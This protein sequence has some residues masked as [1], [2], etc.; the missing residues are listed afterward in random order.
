MKRKGVRRETL[1]GGVGGLEVVTHLQLCSTNRPTSHFPL[2]AK[3][4]CRFCCVRVE[5]ER[6]E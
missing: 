3:S 2:S 5:Q 4:E 1:E 6:S